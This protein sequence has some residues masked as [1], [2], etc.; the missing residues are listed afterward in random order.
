MKPKKA[1]IPKKTLKDVGA[2]RKTVILT[3]SLSTQE[4]L[5]RL[6]AIQQ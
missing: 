4:K 1:L 3:A 6:R 5:K 2:E